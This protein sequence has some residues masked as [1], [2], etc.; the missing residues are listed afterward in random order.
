MK[1][2]AKRAFLTGTCLLGAFALWTAAVSS[3]DVQAIRPEGSAVGLAAIN[4]YVHQR[5][6]V[7]MLLYTL[8]DWLSLIPVGFSLGFAMLGLVQWIRRRSILQVDH[9]ILALGGFY[10]AVI[11]AYAFF[12]AVDINYRPV[13]IEGILE[14][15]YPSSTTMLVLCVMSTAIMQLRMR[16]RSRIPRRWL[17]ALLAAFTAFMVAGR[18]FSGVHWLSDV[19]G[20]MLLSSGLVMLYLGFCRMQTE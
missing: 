13:L 17:T 2:N 6:G 19:I 12:E 20:G 10:L 18:L 14:A 1:A 11:A 5:I 8:T 9:S 16:I 3:I 4:G 15:S 7:H